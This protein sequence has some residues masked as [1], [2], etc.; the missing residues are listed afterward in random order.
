MKVS[1]LHSNHSASRRA[2]RQP[3]TDQLSGRWVLPTVSASR[4]ASGR[5]ASIAASLKSA[6]RHRILDGCRCLSNIRRRSLTAQTDW[7]SLVGSPHVEGPPQPIGL[8]RGQPRCRP[9]IAR[10]GSSLQFV[11]RMRRE[12]LAVDSGVEMRVAGR[13]SL[14]PRWSAPMAG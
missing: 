1:H 7:I 9:N 5:F 12:P 3:K 2:Q 10:A 11:R 6:S 13:S 14:R 4:V 8:Q